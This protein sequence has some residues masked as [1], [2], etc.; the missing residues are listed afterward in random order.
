MW[1][2]SDDENICFYKRGWPFR[3]EAMWMKDK[4][5]KGV[6]KSTWEGY[7]TGCPM[8]NLVTKVDSCRKKLQTWNRLSFGHIRSLLVQKKKLLAQAEALSM[9]RH[10]HKQVRI[11]R[12][13]VY[14]LRIKEDCMWQQRSTV[15]WLKARDLNTSYSCSRANQRNCQNFIS[16]IIRED[17]TIIEEEQ[18]IGKAKVN[19]FQE[20]CTTA[21][22][23][24]LIQSYRG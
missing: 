6:I 3:F 7:H 4:C 23:P 8:S 12:A 20:L 11:L 13:E 21:A 16:K 24:Y 1:I 15:D 14:D 9:S 18:E 5:Y 19:Y 10:N 2:C 22:L 17:G